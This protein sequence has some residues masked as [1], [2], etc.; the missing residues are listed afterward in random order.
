V[1]TGFLY[2][3]G[4]PGLNS[5][6]MGVGLAITV[7]LDVLLIPPFG[8][9]GAAVA[10]AAAYTSTSLALIWFF[11]SVTRGSQPPPEREGRMAEAPAG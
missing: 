10:S 4:R 8:A 11:M 3:T 9:A 2:G 5:L 1:I 6:A 7:I